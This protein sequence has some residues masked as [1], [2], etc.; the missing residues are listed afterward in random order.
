MTAASLDWKMIWRGLGPGLLMAGAAIGVSHLMQSTR[1]GADYGWQLAWLVLVINLVKYPFFLFGHTYALTTGASLLEGYRRL[2]LAWL[3]AFLLL[4]A[5]AAVASIAG[6]TF[7]TA[8]LV[9]NLTGGPLGVA[10]WSAALMGGTTVL[11]LI[12]HYRWLDESMKWVVIALSLATLATFLAAVFHGPAAPNAP[13]K[14]PWDLAS[15]G[16]LIALMGWMPAPIELSVWQSLWIQAKTRTTGVAPTLQQ[17]LWDFNI[18]YI[19]TIVTALMFLGLGALV[20]HGTGT[21]FSDAGAIFAGQ[22]VRIYTATIGEWSGFW[23]GLAALAAMI[24]TTST[25]IDAYPRSLAVGVKLL[26]PALGWSQRRLH[27]A[28]MVLCCAA[29]LVI[30]FQFQASIKGMIDWATTLSF[31]SAPVFAWLNYRVMTDAHVEPAVRP[32]PGLRL[33]CWGSLLFLSGF[34]GLYAV[35]RFFP[36]WLR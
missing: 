21:A 15:L 20:M 26:V 30:V 23:I 35:N 25:V 1:A 19:L 14:S 22:V 36:E 16:F 34:G 12:G 24:S 31:L 18:G 33:W 3:G 28:M 6:V 4:N 7:V 9:Q 2:G 10:G 32:G 5:V 29:S 17:G 27:G 8:A 11:L 13:E